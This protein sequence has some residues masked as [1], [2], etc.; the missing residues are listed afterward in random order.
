M[1]NQSLWKKPIVLQERSV[2]R[3]FDK[4]HQTKPPAFTENVGP[5]APSLKRVHVPF[6]LRS[7]DRIFFV[8]IDRGI[9]RKRLPGEGKV[10]KEIRVVID[11]RCGYIVLLRITAAFFVRV[12][13]TSRWAFWQEKDSFRDSVSRL[14]RICTIADIS[15]EKWERDES[16]YV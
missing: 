5:A 6:F 3:T 16:N 9:A 14:P 1:I 4:K 2:S 11:A 12:E 10:K 7:I 15:S 8:A 13:H